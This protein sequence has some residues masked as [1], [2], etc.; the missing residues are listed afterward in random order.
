M[1]VYSREATPNLVPL[2]D[3]LGELSIACD[4]EALEVSG[5]FSDFYGEFWIAALPDGTRFRVEENGFV[6]RIYR[7]EER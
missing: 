2:E 6:Q 7:K 4:G 5:P 1:I 3:L